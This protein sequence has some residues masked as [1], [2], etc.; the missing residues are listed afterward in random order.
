MK[1]IRGRLILPF[2][3]GMIALTVVLSLY[4]YSAAHKSME[5]AVLVVSRAK[6]D[7]VETS[8]TLLFKQLLSTIQNIVVDP[9]VVSAFEGADDETQRH[10]TNEWMEILIQGNDYYRD[11]FVTDAEGSCIFSSNPGLVGRSYADWQPVQRALGGMFTLEDFDVG[12]ITKKLTAIVAGPVD[13]GAQIAGALVIICDFPRIVDYGK[14]EAGEIKT[15]LLSPAG[16]FEAH[17]DQALMGNDDEVFLELYSQLQAA[18]R[19][20]ERVSY[21]LRGEDYTGFAKVEPLSKWIVI[22]S[23]RDS[24]IFDSARKVG[25]TV[26]GISLAA[27]LVVSFVV[28]RFANGILSTLLSLISYAKRVSEGKFD[29]RLETTTREDELGVLHN[30]LERLVGTLQEMIFKTQEVSRMKGEFL[31]NMS[32]EIR[33]P[34]NAI[35][36]MAHLAL[37]DTE[38]SEKQHDYLDKIQIA[39]RSLLGVIN[40]ILDISK[41]EAGKLVLES[42]PFNI[43]KLLDD[44]A[45]IH[46][47]NV[48]AKSL[49]LIVDC[50]DDVPDFLVGDP[51]RIGQVLNNIL[52]NGIKF[53][54]RG[55]VKVGCRLLKT[56]RGS[57]TIRIDISDTGIGISEEQLA[58]LFQPFTQADASITRQFGGTG[59][60]LA[61][62]RSLLGLMGGSLDVSSE[63]GIGSTF[64]LTVPFPIAVGV[65]ELL[66]DGIPTT[67]D[68]ERLD[69]QEKVILIA[70]DNMINQTILEELVSPSKARLIL[71]ENGREAV[72]AVRR[73]K[74]DLILMDMQMPIMDGLQATKAIRQM[75]EWDG[76]PI[77]A[78][79]ANAMKE[80]REE[81]LAAGMNGYITKPIEIKQLYETLK[82][83][84]AP[85][86]PREQGKQAE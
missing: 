45:A 85:T 14:N 48:N 4:T 21:T 3:M 20:G 63:P 6:T 52:S 44:T 35:M 81:G 86:E 47:I 59:L 25:F 37:R 16:V 65:T 70:E 13:T 18:G 34:I 17:E 36:G 40:D 26:F 24:E 66:D 82:T 38:M 84:L 64:S 61:I 76:L 30:S 56:D 8:M 51:L 39:A 19:Q 57:A 73:G 54:E 5:D 71:A 67:E 22:S 29:S 28:L 49:F 41:I 46:Q 32:H 15:S 1:S 2:L 7:E 79:S 11:I 75:P 31:A 9:H 78:V 42:V 77:I 80:D 10:R 27:L 12:K 58:K 23:G 68:F 43:R 72:E 62:S 69:L 33:T 53:T 50:A 74:V 55:G 83:W 60:G